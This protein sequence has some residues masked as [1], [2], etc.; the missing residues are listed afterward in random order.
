MEASSTCCTRPPGTEGEVLVVV[1]KN[2][3]SSLVLEGIF[4]RPL[5]IEKGGILRTV[6]KEG[7]GY[8]EGQGISVGGAVLGR[9]C[10]E[11]CV[12]STLSS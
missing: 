2:R 12:R 5:A 11:C 8:G 9:K 7:K 4:C 3:M 6:L 1:M 10:Q